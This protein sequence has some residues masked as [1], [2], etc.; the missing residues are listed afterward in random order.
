MDRKCKKEFSK[1]Q[2]SDKWNRMYSD[3]KSKCEEE[4]KSYYLTFVN[5]LKKSNTSQW[6]SKM[7]M[8]AGTK[9]ESI[10]GFGIEELKNKNNVEQAEAI[11]DIC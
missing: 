2:K 11:E 5:D 6:Y 7:K 3:F 4:K 8:M 9:T 1:N 10:Y